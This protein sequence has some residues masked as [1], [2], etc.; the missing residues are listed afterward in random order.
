LG[1]II[2]ISN[3]YKINKRRKIMKWNGCDKRLRK[4]YNAV[5]TS[6]NEAISYIKSKKAEDEAFAIMEEL[7]ELLKNK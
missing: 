5:A 2:H 4:L 1:T 3:K 7:T 6:Q